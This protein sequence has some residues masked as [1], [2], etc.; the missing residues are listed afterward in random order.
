MACNW[1]GNKALPK[2]LMIKIINT[3]FMSKFLQ[4]KFSIC[5]KCDVAFIEPMHYDKS[6]ITDLLTNMLLHHCGPTLYRNL[7]VLTLAPHVD[8]GI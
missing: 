4:M 3:L 2:S 8:L 7:V 5:V 6:I 1:M